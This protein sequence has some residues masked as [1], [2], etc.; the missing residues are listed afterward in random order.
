MDCR[1]GVFCGGGRGG[2]EGERNEAV[3]IMG[4]DWKI[5]ALLR[6]VALSY[7]RGTG[8]TMRVISIR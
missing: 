3:V 1:F 2:G 4:I 8:L 7:D 6:Q 5:S